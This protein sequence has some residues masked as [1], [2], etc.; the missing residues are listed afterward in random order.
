[1]FREGEDQE[2]SGELPE[3]DHHWARLLR[4]GQKKPEHRLTWTVM[5][6]T[7]ID[8]ASNPKNLK[9]REPESFREN[10]ATFASDKEKAPRATSQYIDAPGEISFCT[11]RSHLDPGWTGVSVA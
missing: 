3:G 9:W 7:A 1:M 5:E 6:R 4:R 10:I 8:T 2:Q 11:D